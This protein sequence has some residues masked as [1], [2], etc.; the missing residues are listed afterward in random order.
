MIEGSGSVPRTNIR[1]RIR[2]TEDYLKLEAVSR[3]L[4]RTDPDLVEG[5]FIDECMLRL[6][7]Q[8]TLAR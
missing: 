4:M 3:E 7:A 1:I 8:E 2:N 6:G 5:T